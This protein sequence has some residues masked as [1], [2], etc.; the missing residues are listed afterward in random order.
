M[1]ASPSYN[2]RLDAFLA[3]LVC[4]SSR[5]NV[6]SVF[7]AVRNIPYA[8]RGGRTPEWVLENGEGSC[9]GKHI[10]LRDL[11]RRIGETADVETVE[12][13]FAA[14]IPVVDTMP[15]ALLAWVRSGGIRDYHNY[16]VWHGPGR[17]MKLDATWPDRLAPLGFPVNT[18]W[19][20]KSDTLLALTPLMV[21][22]RVED[23]VSYKVSL[24]AQ[25][26][27]SEATDRLAFLALLT[28]WLSRHVG[29]ETL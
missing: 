20:G 19:A 21:K 12:G 17:E 8:S 22:A 13:D 5:P 11:L 27:E 26:S 3:G 9:S 4:D 24:L 25:L 23:V 6:T 14:G 1:G 18:A 15:Q 28:D 16:V 10:L 7:H 2:T 29:R